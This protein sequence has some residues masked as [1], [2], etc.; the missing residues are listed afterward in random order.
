MAQQSTSDTWRERDGFICLSSLTSDGTTG[1]GWISRFKESGVNLSRYTKNALRSSAFQPTNGISTDIVILRGALFSDAHRIISNIRDV[2]TACKFTK[3]NAE[4]ACLIR[5]MLTDKMIEE[6]GLTWIIVMH[7]PIKEFDRVPI[8]LN[9]SR[10][11]DG[12]RLD[13]DCDKPD[14]RWTRGCG[15]AFALP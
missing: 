4:A 1:D 9:V 8:L 10:N 3:P 14:N 7:E 5:M 6:M 12:C 2:G 11:D 13:A 15:F